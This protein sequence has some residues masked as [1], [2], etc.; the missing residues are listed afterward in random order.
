VLAFLEGLSVED[1]P[2]EMEQLP[3][4]AI[5][6]AGEPEAVTNLSAVIRSYQ[7]SNLRPGI[8]FLISDFLDTGDF[9]VEMKL[10]GGRGFD[11]N[12]IQVLAPEELQPQLTGDL[13]LVDSE[14]G[15]TREVTVN[16]RLLVGYRSALSAYTDSL[17]SFCRT[18]GIGYTIITADASFEDL[19]LN[20]LIEG[21]MAE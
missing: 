7:R 2:D 14:S 10:L 8:V 3:R 18:T 21:R 16:E 5:E 19:L 17:E 13:M 9:R 6:L 1:H 20:R 4:E 15:R 11:L 12:L